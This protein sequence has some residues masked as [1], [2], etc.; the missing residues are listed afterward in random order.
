M[1][2]VEEKLRNEF[3]TRNCKHCIAN[4]NDVYVHCDRGHLLS[5]GGAHYRYEEVIKVAELLY[6][7]IFC[8][9]FEKQF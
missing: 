6:P 3:S 8:P 9:D 5:V 2:S 4:D 7:C 1:S